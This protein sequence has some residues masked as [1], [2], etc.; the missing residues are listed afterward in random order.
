MFTKKLSFLANKKLLILGLAREGLSTVEFLLANLPTESTSQTELV[1]SDRQPLEQLDSVW[2]RLLEQNPNLRYLGSD[3]CR[4]QTFDLVFKTPGIPLKILI[5]QYGLDFNKTNLYSNTQ[6]FFDLLPSLPTP[7]LTIGVTG[8]KGKSTTTSMIYHVLSQN[9]DQVYLAGNIGV[10]PL[11]LLE[12]LPDSETRPIF[13][14]EMSCHQL[15]DLTS[16][17]NFAV[18]L[19]VSPDHLDYYPTFEDYWQAKTAICRFQTADDLVFFNQNSITAQRLASLSQGRQL[20]FSLADQPLVDFI[21]HSG[22]KLA[23]EHNLINTMPAVLIGRQ[24][25]LTDDQI[26]AAIATFKPV[27]HRLELVKTVNQVSYYDDSASSAPEATMAALKAFVGKKIVLIAGGSDKGVEF[28]QL[29][30][31]LLKAQLR[32]LI[33]FPTTGEKILAAILHAD[34]K[35]QLKTNHRFAHSMA[36]AIQLA[37]QAAQAEDVVLLSPGCASYNMF[38]NYED[39]GDQFKALVKAL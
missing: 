14:L 36:E 35:S 19:D 11:R 22:P 27:P 17:P 20:P 24:L 37:S 1:I 34:P 30:Q 18:A 7:P 4:E 26:A 29:A 23:G 2:S 3:E 10:P 6:L 32:Q 5:D 21:K 28:D 25:G 9:L 31:A 8:T 15:A 39:R 38:K 13:V 12:K 33:L 16:S